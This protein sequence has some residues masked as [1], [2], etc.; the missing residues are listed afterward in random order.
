MKWCSAYFCPVHMCVEIP[1]RGIRAS[2]RLFVGFQIL[3]VIFE[4]G[5]GIHCYDVETQSSLPPIDTGF[6]ASSFRKDSIVSRVWL[7]LSA[8][9]PEDLKDV[10]R[11]FSKGSFVNPR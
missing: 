11:R 3:L 8:A 1:G 10:H 4:S 6:K 9:F 7:N 2:L 5:D